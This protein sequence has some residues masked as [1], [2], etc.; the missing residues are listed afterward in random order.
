MKGGKRCPSGDLTPLAD[1]IAITGLFLSYY[2]SPG[3]SQLSPVENEKVRVGFG[4]SKVDFSGIG[5]E[6][7]FWL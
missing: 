4:N 6:A 2:L 1:E 3:L 5:N 7:I